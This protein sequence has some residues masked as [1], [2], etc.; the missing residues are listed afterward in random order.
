ME[1][2]EFKLNIRIIIFVES[3]E[4]TFYALLVP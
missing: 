2:I 4:E 1:K 3:P